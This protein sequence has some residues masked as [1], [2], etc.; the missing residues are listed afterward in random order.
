MVIQTVLLIK[1][2]METYSIIKYY[3]LMFLAKDLF[4]CH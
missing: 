3:L 2:L 4:L 1:H